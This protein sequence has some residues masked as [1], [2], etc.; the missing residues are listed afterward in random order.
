YGDKTNQYFGQSVAVLGDIDGDGIDDLVAG[1]PGQMYFSS[2]TGLVRILSGADGSIL[3]TIPGLSVGDQ[4]GTWVATLGDLDL[5]GTLDYVVGAPGVDVT[6]SES[7][8][9]YAIS[10]ATGY[11]FYELDGAAAGDRLGCSVAALGDVDGDGFG[12]FVAG[13]YGQYAWVISGA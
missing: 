2:V 5:D 13:S 7:G 4:F 8:A 6:G 9:V 12:D 3:S 10:G 11:T 1:G